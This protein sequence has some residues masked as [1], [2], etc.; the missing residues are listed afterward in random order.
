MAF[1]PQ[2][3]IILSAIEEMVRERKPGMA[4]DALPTPNEYFAAIMTGL[5]SQDQSH[6][7]EVRLWP[8]LFANQWLAEGSVGLQRW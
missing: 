1:V 8:L 2:Q 5:E 7:P 4:A 3:V 6:T